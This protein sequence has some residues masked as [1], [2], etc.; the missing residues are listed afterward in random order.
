MA[1]C[2][3]IQRGSR[4]RALELAVLAN[5]QIRQLLAG[6]GYQVALSQLKV[7]STSMYHMTYASCCGQVIESASE[8]AFVASTK[9]IQEQSIE[10]AY[11][12][13]SVGLS[14]T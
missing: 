4:D 9:L 10:I 7:P 1:I 2:P 14:R 11:S 6:F 5:L 13:G 12:Y 8:V 3:L